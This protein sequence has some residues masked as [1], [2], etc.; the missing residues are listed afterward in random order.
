MTDD[1]L[2]A[3]ER[4]WRD[5][6]DDES[7]ARL[8]RERRRLGLLDE[9]ALEL[10]A[11]LGYAPAREV[12]GAAAPA[13]PEED[14][15]E[16]WAGPIA[17]AT[18]RLGPEPCLRA[19]AAAAWRVPMHGDRFDGPSDV[20]MRVLEAL[21][22]A[23]L[24]PPHG[25]KDAFAR[26]EQALT[27]AEQDGWGATNVLNLAHIALAVHREPENAEPL[28]RDALLVL[29]QSGLY[30]RVPHDEVRRE[31]ALFALDLEDPSRGRRRERGR[32]FG[33]ESEIVRAIAFSPDG[34][35]VVTTNRAGFVTLR[36]AATGE[37]LRSMRD[38]ATDMFA[39]A[40]TRDGARVL[41]GGAWGELTAWDAATGEPVGS[42][43]AH[44]DGVTRVGVLPDGR[45]VSAGYDRALRV[46][47][48][49]GGE[50]LLAL[51]GGHERAIH[52][53]ALSR[54]GALAA[55]GGSDGRA[56][57][58]DLQAG[59]ARFTATHPAGVTGAA[60]TPDGARLV[61]SCDDRHL[62]AWDVASGR[63]VAAHQVAERSIYGMALSPCGAFAVT[64]GDGEVRL[65]RVADGA[66]IREWTAPGVQLAAAFAPDGAWALVGARSGALRRFDLE[67]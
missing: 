15:E 1:R 18:A 28:L 45:V 40:F 66:T 23:L 46:W 35:R 56:V 43:M 26:F 20:G 31:L 58:W 10:G 9:R 61:T 48:A 57:V 4:A 38:R 21:D 41:V 27:Q 32:R 64:V 67:V 19:V 7:A 44:Q 55:T 25:R 42:W 5:A 33:A 3:A 39:A 54:D 63:E 6:R 22:D 47:S 30:H 60:F 37:V 52:A 65:V 24:A 8:L 14:E 13:E 49:R 17:A 51:E 62:R 11:L 50:P 29:A 2:R 16:A 59:A 36:D 12:L 34:A 53:L